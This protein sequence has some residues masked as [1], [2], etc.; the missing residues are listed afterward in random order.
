MSSIRKIRVITFVGFALILGACNGADILSSSYVPSVNSSSSVSL[1]APGELLFDYY[2]N[3]STTGNWEQ[4]DENSGTVKSLSTF[5]LEIIYYKRFAIY[6]YKYSNGAKYTTD[7]KKSTIL[8]ESGNWIYGRDFLFKSWTGNVDRIDADALENDFEAILNSYNG[9]FAIIKEV[10]GREIQLNDF[11]PNWNTL[12]NY[13][14]NLYISPAEEAAIELAKLIEKILITNISYYR[15]S[16]EYIDGS[17]TITNKTGKTI[18]YMTMSI[19][20]HNSNNQVINSEFT[21]QGTLFNNSSVTKSL[22]NRMQGYSYNDIAYIT[23]VITS[24]RVEN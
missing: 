15:S 17:F 7:L 9:L 1:L 19:L 6:E 10:Y 12:I 14:T 3:V 23:V 11:N 2:C 24:V 20:Y 13:E 21:N 18:N 8:F 22:I 4:C 5:G 16:L